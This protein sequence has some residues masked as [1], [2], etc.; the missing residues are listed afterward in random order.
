M[1][2]KELDELFSRL[3]DKDKFRLICRYILK[4][5]ASQIA[6]LENKSRQAI[7]LS[8]SKSECVLKRINHHDQLVD[9]IQ[10]MFSKT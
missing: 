6:C 5:P 8:F 9:Y 10:Q 4:L 7:F 2:Y 3:S 1:F